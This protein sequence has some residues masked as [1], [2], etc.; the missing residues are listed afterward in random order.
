M[1]PRRPACTDHR[2]AY[3]SAVERGDDRDLSWDR[4]RLGENLAD[5][6]CQVPLHCGP[7][8]ESGLLDTGRALGGVALGQRGR[9]A[10]QGRFAPTSLRLVLARCGRAGDGGRTG[11]GNPT[12]RGGLGAAAR[13]RAR[14][15]QRRTG[16][17][18]WRRIPP[19][20]TS[21]ACG[22]GLGVHGLACPG[23]RGCRSHT[24]GVGAAHGAGRAERAYGAWR[25][26]AIPG[27][28]RRRSA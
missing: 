21:P 28:A 3:G 5:G 22:R 19:R 6:Q 8:A 26:L 4:A 20:G 11:S 9:R 23:R 1:G 24:C 13:S 10:D 27:G 25:A 16:R 7:S 12:R 2:L 15:A 18:G 17:D 14:P